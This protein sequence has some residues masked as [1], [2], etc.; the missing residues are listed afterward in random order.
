MAGPLVDG[1]TEETA[2]LGG[3]P[4]AWITPSGRGHAPGDGPVLLYLH[5][6]AYEIGSIA[7]YRRFASELA[8]LLGAA[9]AVVEYR[10]AP[11]DPYPAAV[12][13]AVTA[14]ADLVAAGHAPGSV[15]LMGDSAGGGLALATLLAL[16]RRGLPQPAAAVALSPWADLTLTADS[17]DRCAATDP[18]LD[19]ARLSASAVNY[20]AGA[21]PHDPLVSPAL[22]PPEEWAGRAPVLVQSSAAEALADDA[23][24][25]GEAVRAAGG[26]VQVELWPDLTHVWHVMDQAIPEVRD[27]RATIAEFLRRRWT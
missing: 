24:R 5:G 16:G 13:D 17:Y 9:V 2:T 12:D 23:T 7:S 19:R 25:V 8:L 21:D 6:G 27:A 4:T 11:E 15:A 14:Y 10:L 18:Y 26:E 3:R 20:L 22:A 1:T